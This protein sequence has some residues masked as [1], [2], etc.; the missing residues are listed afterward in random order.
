MSVKHNVVNIG[1]ETVTNDARKKTSGQF[2]RLVQHTNAQRPDTH[3]GILHVTERR[4]THEVMD[5]LQSG[6]KAK[7]GHNLIESKAEPIQT[8]SQLVYT[9]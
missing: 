8:P 3:D 4:D 7:G 6:E 1:L 9:P 5:M 2:S